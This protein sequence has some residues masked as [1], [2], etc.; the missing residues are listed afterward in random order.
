[1]RMLHLKFKVSC[2][3]LSQSAVYAITS[4][5]FLTF[6][7]IVSYVISV[8]YENARPMRTGCRDRLCLIRGPS[9]L[10]YLPFSL[11]LCL[12]YGRCLS[13]HFASRYVRQ[14][15]GDLEEPFLYL[16]LSLKI[17]FVFPF[18]CCTPSPNIYTGCRCTCM[19]SFI[20]NAWDWG[21]FHNL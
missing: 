3:Y 2:W 10:H 20:Q 6:S 19:G 18:T 12:K 7:F 13:L 15:Q 21:V 16:F 14:Y 1:M 4:I 5:W 11:W 8:C 17:S 9:D